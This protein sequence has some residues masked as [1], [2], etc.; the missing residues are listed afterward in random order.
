MVPT[1][2]CSRYNEH[3]LE[4][5]DI[6]T[7]KGL[8]NG[9]A[10]GMVF[11]PLSISYGLSFWYGSKLVFDGL[12]SPGTIVTVSNGGYPCIGKYIGGVVLNNVISLT[13]FAN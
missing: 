6:T 12:L 7:K 4:A 11:L 10:L 9:F 2:I 8:I 5:R 1:S 13:I 3:L